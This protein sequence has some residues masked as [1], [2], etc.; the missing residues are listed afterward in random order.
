[1]RAGERLW[2]EVQ[3]AP[4]APHQRW[5]QAPLMV[6]SASRPMVFWPALQLIQWPLRSCPPRQRCS[7]ADS[8]SVVGAT[9]GAGAHSTVICAGQSSSIASLAAATLALSSTERVIGG[10]AR[11]QSATVNDAPSIGCPSSE[12]V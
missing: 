9:D 10:S 3:A 4:G 6:P 11:T 8:S 1:M 2:I 7:S 5:R 12:T